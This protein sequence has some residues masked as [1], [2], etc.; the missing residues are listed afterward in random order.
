MRQRVKS[1]VGVH[2]HDDP[3]W[4]G[5]R[6]SGLGAPGKRHGYSHSLFLKLCRSDPPLGKFL[7]IGDIWQCPRHISFS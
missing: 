1:D 6:R 7:T 2:S 4:R 3:Q 5:S